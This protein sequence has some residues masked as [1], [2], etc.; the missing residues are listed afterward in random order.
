MQA[1]MNI[2]KNGLTDNFLLTLENAFKNHEKVKIRILKS[3]GHEK[4][5]VVEMNK[6]I[7]ER[8]GKKY[9]SRIVGFTIS[10]QKWRKERR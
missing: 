4:A 8:L 6:K 2:G 1:E 3:G 10:V 7:L 9:T 5:Q